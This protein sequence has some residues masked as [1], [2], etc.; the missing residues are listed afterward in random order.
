MWANNRTPPPP[1]QEANQFQLARSLPLQG[2]FSEQ[3]P[4]WYYRQQVD[5]K[6]KSVILALRILAQCRV[7]LSLQYRSCAQLASYLS[8]RIYIKQ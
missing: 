6:L 8:V 4:Y 2:R 1:N 7:S 3:K 5:V